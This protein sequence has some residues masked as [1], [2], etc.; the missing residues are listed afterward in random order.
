MTHK[1]FFALTEDLDCKNFLYT[2]LVRTL[3]LS[4]IFINN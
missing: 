1:I 2:V 3:F 4:E